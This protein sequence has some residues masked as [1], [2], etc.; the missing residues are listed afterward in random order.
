MLGVRTYNSVAFETELIEIFKL[1]LTLVE[2]VKIGLLEGDPG[3][4]LINLVGSV[5]DRLPLHKNHF[6]CAKR[7]YLISKI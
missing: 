5:W 4:G 6:E 7:S 2:L 1:S 3:M